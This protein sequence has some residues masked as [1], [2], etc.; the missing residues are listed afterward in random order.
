MMIATDAVTLDDFLA[1][2]DTEPAS[3]WVCGEVHQKPMPDNSHGALQ[4]YVGMLLFQFLQGTKLGRARPEWRCIF[5]PRGRQRIYVP[6]VVYVSYERMPPG[7]IR[8][9]RFV[10]V[11][12]DLIV[13]VL[14]PDQPTVRFTRKIYFCLRHGVRLIWVLD[15]REQSITVFAPGADDV[16]LRAG[17]TLDGG[18]VL[19]GFSVPVADIMAQLKD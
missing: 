11:A 15:P 9:N 7:D 18:E 12:P 4:L 14:S 3:E 5:G 16:V 13:E 17:D 19:P 10:R 2:A 1:E 6:D 8:V